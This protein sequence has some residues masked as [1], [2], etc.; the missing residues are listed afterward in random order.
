M[1]ILDRNI[2]FRKMKPMWKCLKPAFLLLTCWGRL[3]KK[4]V[5][6]KVDT[7]MSL[8]PTSFMSS[9]LW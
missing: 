9:L 8:L 1:E 6:M 4:S 7:K 2:Q 5:C 3:K